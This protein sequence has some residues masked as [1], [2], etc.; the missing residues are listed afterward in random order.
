V[1][2]ARSQDET[3][4]SLDSPQPE[5]ARRPLPDI[6][7]HEEEVKLPGGTSD[8]LYIPAPPP[9][10][11]GRELFLRAVG[12]V[13]LVAFVSLAVQARGLFGARG[14]SPF[15]ERDAL[16]DSL[17]HGWAS[18]PSLFRMFPSLQAEPDH[19][20]WV[21]AAFAL[22]LVIGVLPPVAALGAWL[23]YLSFVT[24]GDPF[25]SFQWDALLLE[26]SALAFLL[27]P[28]TLR[29][30]G[31]RRKPSAA[32]LRWCLWFLVG[33]LVFLSGLVKLLSGSAPWRDGTALDFHWWTQPLPNPASWWL[34]QMPLWCD[35]AMTFGSLGVELLAPLL[36]PFGR[37]P[38]A[39][40][41][42]LILLL[43]IGITLSG[44]YGFFDLLTAALALSL[45]DDDIFRRVLR[46]PLNVPIPVMVSNAS[47]TAHAVAASVA[48]AIA[49]LV[50]IPASIA[51]S[52]RVARSPHTPFD[53]LPGWMGSV[54][55]VPFEWG[56]RWRLASGYG[57]FAEMTIAR[58]EITIEASLDG[59]TWEP[60]IFRYKPGPL[61][62]R[63]PI[64][65]LH[66]PRL[67]WQMWFAAIS[68]PQADHWQATL[69]EA[70]LEARPEVL[71]LLERVPF[72]GQR[73]RAVR[74]RRD[75][76]GFSTLDSAV[77]QQGEWW[78]ES[79]RGRPVYG[80]GR[81]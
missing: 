62:R 50:A 44:N 32:P 37:W 52:Q 40:S 77:A 63:P 28:W 18:F 35:R 57:L 66:M 31:G 36:I 61:D 74:W 55:G 70:L 15:S 11:L 75:R 27:A 13:Q 53:A 39:V 23:I 76:Y 17:G 38:R 21:G 47:M 6:T 58:P 71:A 46:R 26:T 14:L 72:D 49:L 30:R 56:S 80:F 78:I 10:A 41:A 54:L 73:P 43:Q 19:V 51:W 48:V 68:W 65:P 29:L 4:I 12:V 3:P 34:W 2:D 24:M 79:E 64:V 22:A 8:R 16:L 5:W 20:A 42:L 45:I 67:D 33:R 7:S 81:R 1:S 25:M 9:W 59:A 69:H 60:Y